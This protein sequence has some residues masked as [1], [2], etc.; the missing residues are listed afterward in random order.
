MILVGRDHRQHPVKRLDPVPPA[1]MQAE[2]RGPEIS[3]S[4]DDIG[5]VFEGL[6]YSKLRRQLLDDVIWEELLLKEA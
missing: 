2:D 6:D 4:L 5:A 1:T 3:L